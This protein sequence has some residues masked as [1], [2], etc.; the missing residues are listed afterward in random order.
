[1]NYRFLALAFLLPMLGACASAPERSSDQRQDEARLAACRRD[2]E[3]AILFRDRGQT[4]IMVNF[5]SAGRE[6]NGHVFHALDAANLL[7]NFGDAG[8]AGETFGTKN[9]VGRSSHGKYLSFV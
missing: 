3:R 4:S 8:G 9:S 6:V 7:L 5:D 2:A 1:M